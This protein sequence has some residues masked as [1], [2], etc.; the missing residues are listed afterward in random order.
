MIS[1][2]NNRERRD[3]FYTND[4]SIYYYDYLFLKRYKGFC[5]EILVMLIGRK[6]P[7]F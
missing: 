6:T 3:I 7:I 2:G 1:A 5:L 4:T